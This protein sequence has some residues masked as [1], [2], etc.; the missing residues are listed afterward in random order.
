MNEFIT[1]SCSSTET[2][3]VAKEKAKDDWYYYCEDFNSCDECDEKCPLPVAH[4]TTTNNYANFE[5]FHT[6]SK[7]NA[8][9]NMIPD[10]KTDICAL[11]EGSTLTSDCNTGAALTMSPKTCKAQVLA[12]KDCLNADTVCNVDNCSLCD[13]SKEKCFACDHGF[14]NFVGKCYEIT[15][16]TAEEKLTYFT[17]RYET[18]SS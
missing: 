16:T 3:P 9:D 17:R 7:C 14:W 10:L 18:F 4:D 12:W 11:D 15:D 8:L 5:C 6:D 1:D 2:D 13:D